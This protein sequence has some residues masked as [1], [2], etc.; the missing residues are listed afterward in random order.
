M[1]MTAS[2]A[3]CETRKSFSTVTCVFN[4]TLD[5][6]TCLESPWV[7]VTGRCKELKASF[8][9]HSQTQEIQK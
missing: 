7:C 2:S 3:Y 9:P 1:I 4:Y 5:F 6:F 8:S